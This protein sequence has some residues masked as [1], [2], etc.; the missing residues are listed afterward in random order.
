MHVTGEAIKR[1]LSHVN[2][3]GRIQILSSTPWIVADG[4][5]NRDSMKK[6]VEAV[7]ENFRY[8]TCFVIFGTSCDKDIDGMATEILSLTDRIVVTSSSH[9][10]SAAVS[11]L[12][13]GFAGHDVRV[14][15]ANSVH[16]AISK[17]KAC[18]GGNDLVLVTG[19]IFI[20]AEAIEESN[21]HS[22]NSA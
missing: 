7:K 10:R 13:E 6:L 5:H 17:V 8:H 21:A 2:W 11:S 15:V 18:A 3:P 9:P 19:S 16:D 1:G 22:D 14:D 20:V 12:V 4:A